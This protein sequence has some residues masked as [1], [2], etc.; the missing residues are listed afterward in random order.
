MGVNTAIFTQSG[1][2]APRLSQTEIT[3]DAYNMANEAID[4]QKV[5]GFISATVS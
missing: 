2:C 1:A 5:A 4:F 3:F